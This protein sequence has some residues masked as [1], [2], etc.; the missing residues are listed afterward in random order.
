MTFQWYKDAAPVAGATGEALTLEAFG[1]E[2][3]GWYHLVATSACGSVATEPVEVRL[4]TVTPPA[5]VS[6]PGNAGACVG[7]PVTL[8]AGVTA[9][10]GAEQY[11]WLRGAAG[12][13][14]SAMTPV[15]GATSATLTIPAAQ[16]SD[17]GEYRLRVTWACGTVL[18]DS[19]RVTIEPRRPEV[20]RQPVS[21]TVPNGGEARMETDVVERDT[22]A[23]E[24]ASL[25]L[26]WHKDMAPV[27]D[28][29]RISGA[30]TAILEIRNVR[31]GDAGQYQL[32]VVNACTSVVSSYAGLVVEGADPPP[33]PTPT[34]P[35]TY[36]VGPPTGRGAIGGTGAPARPDGDGDGGGC[37][38]DFNGNG[39]VDADDL[40]DAIACYQMPVPCAALDLDGDGD[41]D[42][43]DL[44]DM[45]AAYFG[46]C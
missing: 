10:S 21:A 34:P 36:V 45:I 1:A 7:R 27:H 33:D 2:R 44:A 16:V 20:T 5:V 9:G 15:A 19:A 11:Q 31:T 46:G 29:A 24:A 6:H 8:V 41:I 17:A 35:P 39:E 30:G 28:S 4:S 43:D 18:S 32:L 38:A 26:R 14:V 37:V 42:S 3:A 12:A 22:P 13:S 40:A 25:T 23:G